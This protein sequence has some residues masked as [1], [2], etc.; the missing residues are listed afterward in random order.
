MSN[1][2]IRFDGGPL[3]GQ[4]LVPL[5]SDEFPVAIT[6]GLVVGNRVV[7]HRY[8]AYHGY[9]DAEGDVIQMY[10]HSDAEVGEET[11]SGP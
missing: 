9:L 5:F 10:M 3:D 2:Y 7:H 1:A 6:I 4:G 11:V 8:T